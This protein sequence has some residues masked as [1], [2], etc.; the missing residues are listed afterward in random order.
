[1]TV[2]AEQ[3]G[4]KGEVLVT[5]AQQLGQIHADLTVGAN[6]QA[7]TLEPDAPIKPYRN[8]KDLTD[9]SRDM[10][11]IDCHELTAEQVRSRYP[12][13]YQWLLD[14]VKTERDVNR[15]KAA[16]LPE[17]VNAVVQALGRAHRVAASGIELWRA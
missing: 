9:V 11:E 2:T 4:P 17:Q 1:M 15:D 14:H 16:T 12:K 6:V 13:L 10:L 7:A 3:P 5:L 8:G